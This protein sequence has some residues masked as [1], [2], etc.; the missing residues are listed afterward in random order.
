MERPRPPGNE[1]LITMEQYKKILELKRLKE[2]GKKPY[3]ALAEELGLRGGTVLS[4]VR[5]GIKRYDY[6]IWKESQKRGQG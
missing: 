6:A 5:K 3:T 2:I 1:P 4:A